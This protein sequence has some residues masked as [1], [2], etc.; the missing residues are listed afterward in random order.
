MGALSQEIWMEGEGGSLCLPWTG[1]WGHPWHDQDE[2][3]TCRREW[4]WV[5]KSVL[6]KTIEPSEAIGRAYRKL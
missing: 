1:S 6:G 3:K 2:D 5:L 4:G